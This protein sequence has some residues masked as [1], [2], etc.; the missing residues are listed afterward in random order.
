MSRHQAMTL[1]RRAHLFAG[2]LMMPWAL[3]YALSGFMFNHPSS[4]AFA[5]DRAEWVVLREAVVPPQ[6]V[7]RAQD[8]ARQVISSLNS[9]GRNPN[10]TT[11][12][13]MAP[14]AAVEITAP[15][16][17]ARL[18]RGGEV[19]DLRY[20]LGADSALLRP[21]HSST[22]E[23]SDFL[24]RLHKAHTYPNAVAATDQFTATRIARAV[25][26]DA[27]AGMLCFWAL[28][29]LAMWWMQ[30]KA[31]R[32]SG[33]VVITCSLLIALGVGWEM[34]RYFLTSN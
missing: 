6:S 1:L 3:L 9:T 13:R 4:F 23:P 21:F 14:G 17:I 29:G 33:L 25:L 7:P 10:G 34:Y 8:L 22:L 15:V 26:V 28:S 18:E 30:A 16:L 19:V 5:Q 20:E 31:L 24:T 27:M 12:Y 2:L 32:R 11:P